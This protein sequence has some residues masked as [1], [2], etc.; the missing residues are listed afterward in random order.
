M[1]L[2]DTGLT[3]FGIEFIPPKEKEKELSAELSAPLDNDGAALAAAQ[4]VAGAYS[5]ALDIEGQ[6]KND[7]EMVQKYREISLYPEIDIAIQDIINEA[8]PQ[9]AES[10]QVEIELDDLDVSDN[11][12]E[13]I[14]KEFDIVLK[15]LNYNE[16]SSEIFRRWYIDG[17]IFYQVIVDKNNIKNG[18]EK[19]NLID[20][21]KIRK[22]R[23]IKKKK[24]ST[25][26]DVIEGTEDYFLFNEAGFQVNQQT[27]SVVTANSI[28]ITPDSILYVPSGFT[29]YNSGLILSHLHKAIRPAN[30]L[31]MLED[32][33]VIYFIARAPERR[34]FYVDV[35]NLPK[36]KAEQH[37]KDMMNRYR[38]K[39]VYDGKT[40]EVRDDKRYQSMLEDFWM[41]RRDGGKGTEITT[42]EGASNITGMLDN[43]EYFRTKLYQ[44]LNIPTSRLQGE[45]GFNLGRSSEISRDEV[46]FQKFVNRLRL[47][48]SQLFFDALRV[49]LITKEYL[50]TE[51]W[52]EIKQD[53]RFKFQADNFFTEL[54]N[55]EMLQMRL[56]MLD[57]I[58]P[59]LGKYFSKKS[60][61]KDILARSDKEIE[62]N[63][64]DID[65]E[66]DDI[67]AQPNQVI[68]NQ[69]MMDQQTEMGGMDPGG[70]TNGQGM[71]SQAVQGGLGQPPS[72]SPIYDPNQYQ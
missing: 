29:D 6:I 53:I 8:I 17:R 57:Q 28:K 26:V 19:L 36:L 5:V 59:Y 51:E 24:T 32:A 4:Q 54:K 27:G 34:V 55:L 61:Q 41:P 72:K 58:D 43:V 42:L 52:E 22:V 63:E 31:R 25:G 62:Q 56:Q 9:E 39:M 70:Q 21:N 45:S 30:L 23:E 44:A 7:I 37:M 69:Q 71:G 49:Q 50:N 33:T 35:G 60:V 48:F 12:K 38:N 67:T 64:E 3:L 16:H 11:L 68:A 2:F 20:A 18:I 65:A 40:G 15:K 47:R 66:K 1:A 46:K 10:S 14:R 13:D